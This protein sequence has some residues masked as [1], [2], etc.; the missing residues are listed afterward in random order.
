M[1]Q[2]Y[3]RLKDSTSNSLVLEQLIAGTVQS[4]QSL[5]YIGQVLVLSQHRKTDNT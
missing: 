5:L 4:M 2:Q 1:T 3:A